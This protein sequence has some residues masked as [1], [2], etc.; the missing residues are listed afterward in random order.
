MRKL[1]ADIIMEL[2][3][4]VV[5]TKTKSNGKR[6]SYDSDG[7]LVKVDYEKVN[8]E[9]EK[10]DYARSRAVAYDP[11]PEQLDQIYHNM[12]NWKDRIKAVKAKFPKPS[13]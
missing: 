12:D 7:K 8:K 6:E 13:K 11:I 1:D 3:P 5:S 9:Y 2:H 10:Q 4:N